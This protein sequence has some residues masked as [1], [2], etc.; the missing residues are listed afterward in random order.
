MNSSPTAVALEERETPTHLLDGVTIMRYAHV[1]RDRSS[2]G[3]EQYLRHLNYGILKKH[4]LTILQMHLSDQDAFDEP[5]IEDVGLGRI[6]WVP[7]PVLH[8]KPGLTDFLRR[9]RFVH[10]RPSFRQYRKGVMQQPGKLSGAASLWRHRGGHL[11][12]RSTILSDDLSRLLSRRDIDLLILHWLSY[13]VEALTRTAK[14]HGIPFVFINH[15]D[16]ALLSSP[17][18]RK[19]IRNAA[20]VGTVSNCGIPDGFRGRIVNLSDAVDAEFFSPQKAHPIP[21]PRGPI[22]LLAA[23]VG[24]G[25]GHDDLLKAARILADRKIDFTLCFA[26]A[27]ES[28]SLHQ[29]VQSTARVMGLQE[30]ILFLGERQPEEIRDWYAHST[31]IVLPSHS[32]GLGR[33]L[34]E[35]QAMKKPVVAYDC[36]GVSAA[37]R[38]DETGFLVKCGQIEDFANKIAVLLQNDAE[39][40]RMGALGRDFVTRQF[41]IASLIQRHEAFYAKALQQ[42]ARHD[43]SRDLV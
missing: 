38:P 39:R 21:T 2:G 5:E 35:A 25:K 33:V 37:L 26:G 41:S 12:Y 32:E 30:R 19:A 15:F 7:V 6:L 10:G 11:R 16:N 20:A 31:V 13:D 8:G 40:L 18:A 3:V 42:R 28:A 22:I 23:R 27:I 24:V 17:M 43:A 1:Y 34:L 29:Q 14:K 4:R 36:G 9:I